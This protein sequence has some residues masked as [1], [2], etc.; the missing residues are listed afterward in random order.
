MKK[1]VY[2]NKKEDFK[3]VKDAGNRGNLE[4]FYKFTSLQPCQLIPKS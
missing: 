4:K 3:Y 1:K 2:L